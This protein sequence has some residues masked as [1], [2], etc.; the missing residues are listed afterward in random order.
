MSITKATKEIRELADSINRSDDIAEIHSSSA[1]I[2]ELASNI[3]KPIEGIRDMLGKIWDKDHANAILNADHFINPVFEC[4][5]HK[6]GLKCIFHSQGHKCATL[7]C[8][9]KKPD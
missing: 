8:K 3:E 6:A 4:P 1:R 9:I 5:S 2:S 7:A